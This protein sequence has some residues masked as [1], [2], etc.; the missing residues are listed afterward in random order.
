MTSPQYISTTTHHT[1]NA[2]QHHTKSTT[3]NQ[4]QSSLRLQSRCDLDLYDLRWLFRLR[5]LSSTGLQSRPTP[6]RRR[7]CDLDTSKASDSD[8][9]D[10]H[11]EDVSVDEVGF[12]EL[13]DGDGRGEQR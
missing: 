4:C 8:H 12:G 7:S 11:S 9:S 6:F 3:A 1:R 13:R 5:K 2:T 10:V